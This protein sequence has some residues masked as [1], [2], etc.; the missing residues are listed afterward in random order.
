MSFGAV[1]RKEFLHQDGPARVS[2][3]VKIYKLLESKKVPNVDRLERFENSENHL[4]YVELSPIGVDR[5]PKSGSEALDLVICMLEAL[6]V[7]YD[8]SAL[9]I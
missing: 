4:P 9:V 3:L 5:P 1:I 7:C 8:V 2:E 6:K